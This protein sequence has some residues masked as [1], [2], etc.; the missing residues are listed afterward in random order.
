MTDNRGDGVKYLTLDK[1]ELEY[2]RVVNLSD[3]RRRS[4]VRN[5]ELLSKMERTLIK[6]QIERRKKKE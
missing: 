5:R 6:Q 3:V 2:M 4:K 1:K